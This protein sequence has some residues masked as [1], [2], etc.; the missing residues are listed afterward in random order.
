MKNSKANKQLLGTFSNIPKNLIN[1]IDR[2]VNSGDD[3]GCED[4]VVVDRQ[5]FLDLVEVCHNL[6][7]DHIL[8]HIKDD[9]EDDE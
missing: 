6:G 4:L 8:T 9:E 2:L 1:A 7:M 3:E 5:C